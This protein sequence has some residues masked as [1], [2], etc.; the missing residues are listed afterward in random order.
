MLISKMR[1]IKEKQRKNS[2]FTL[3]EVVIAS[4]IIAAVIATFTIF[5]LNVTVIQQAT[6]LDRIATRTMAGEL[7]KYSSAKWDDLMSPPPS[8]SGVGCVITSTRKSLQLVQTGPVTIT[9]DGLRVS[10]T[11]SVTWANTLA[12]ITN[13]VGNGTTITYT[14]VNSFVAG[15]VISVYEMRPI[16]YNLINVTV[17]TASPTQFTVTNP[18]TGTFAMGGRAGVSVYCS[19]VKDKLDLKVLTVSVA[20]LN[21]GVTHSKSATIYRSVWTSGIKVN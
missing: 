21:K 15:Q 12:P 20:W 9:S 18:G 13:A 7:E 14:A 16:A 17:A 6:T 10:V 1:Y 5:L 4:G 8:G 2:G 19:G 11:R 3:A